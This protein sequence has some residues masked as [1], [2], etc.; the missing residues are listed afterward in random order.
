MAPQRNEGIDYAST[1]AWRQGHE[2]SNL[3][4]FSKC[5]PT[6][7]TQED[8]LT[9]MTGHMHVD[10]SQRSVISV[11]DSCEKSSLLSQPLGHPHRHVRPPILIDEEGWRTPAGTVVHGHPER[12]HGYLPVIQVKASERAYD[13]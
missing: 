12:V 5:A 13:I 11:P 9:H 10:K 8:V 6:L 4:K 1:L 3:F 7:V 2:A